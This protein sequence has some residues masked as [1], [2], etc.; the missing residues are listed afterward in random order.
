[1]DVFRQDIKFENAAVGDRCEMQQ[2]KWRRSSA[3]FSSAGGREDGKA[4]A[5][6]PSPADNAGFERC[7]IEAF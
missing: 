5:L 1:M 3:Y 6:P 2:A 4:V 7:L